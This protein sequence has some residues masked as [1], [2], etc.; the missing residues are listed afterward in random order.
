M[1]SDS[2]L[3]FKRLPQSDYNYM[4]CLP[5]MCHQNLY[6]FSIVNGLKLSPLAMSI[7]AKKERFTRRFP[8]YSPLF[9]VIGNC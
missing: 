2:L 7:V 3:L 1:H 9:G 4:Q 6:L 8:K 5:S